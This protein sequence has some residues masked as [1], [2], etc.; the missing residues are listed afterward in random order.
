MAIKAAALVIQGSSI[1]MV[2][3]VIISLFTTVV[4]G[5]LLKMS[6]VHHMVDPTGA[7]LM[8]VHTTSLMEDLTN[9]L[10]GNNLPTAVSLRI[11]GNNALLIRVLQVD[12]KVVMGLIRANFECR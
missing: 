5:R 8:A 6:M 11:G 1:T 4:M 12:G 7:H 10:M 3:L 2:G 9:L